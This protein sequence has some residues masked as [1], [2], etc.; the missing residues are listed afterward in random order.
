MARRNKNNN[1]QSVKLPVVDF[2]KIKPGD[3]TSHELFVNGEV[4]KSEQ[5]VDSI[6]QMLNYYDMQFVLVVLNKNN[7]MLVKNIQKAKSR[8]SATQSL[9]NMHTLAFTYNVDI[10]FKNGFV[11]NLK[12]WTTEGYDIVDSE[13][14][15]YTNEDGSDMEFINSFNY[16]GVKLFPMGFTN[17]G[18]KLTFKERYQS[19]VLNSF[20]LDWLINIQ[21]I[22]KRSI[23][24]A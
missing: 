8:L 9:Y 19:Y 14:S 15:I 18:T 1:V 11:L 17:I 5:Q 24:A 22:G 3:E 10:T 7:G 6:K 20:L 13:L 23:N 2:G 16:K 4:I 21:T 12:V